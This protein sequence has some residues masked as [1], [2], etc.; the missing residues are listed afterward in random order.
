[1][2]FHSAAALAL[3]NSFSFLIPSYAGGNSNNQKAKST[4]KSSKKKKKRKTPETTTPADETRADPRR[5][6][7]IKRPDVNYNDSRRSHLPLPLQLNS[8][9]GNVVGGVV[10]GAVS[11]TQM[12]QLT[13]AGLSPDLL[14]ETQEVN[15]SQPHLMSQLRDASVPP[16]PPLD[17]EVIPEHND[18]VQDNEGN[19]IGDPESPAKTI[20]S[21]SSDNSSSSTDRSAGGSVGDD[22][23]EPSSAF[24]P[25]D[26]CFDEAARDFPLDQRLKHFM[27][28]RVITEQNRKP[29]ELVL[30][31]AAATFVIHEG[32]TDLEEQGTLLVNKYLEL[33]G[34][35]DD[36]MFVD[37][38]IQANMKLKMKG[39]Q[40]ELV[41]SS[42]VALFKSYKKKRAEIRKIFSRLPTDFST[43]KS[44]KQLYDIYEGFI[45]ACFI[46]RKVSLSHHK[47]NIQIT[48]MFSTSH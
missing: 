18:P 39:M 30:L 8:K 1:M 31:A 12:S 46:D 35:L 21:E 34:M 45:I 44:G 2:L 16:L 40:N 4:E 22:S 7:P 29:V 42:G 20:D 19:L 15:D 32:K 3:R 36:D 11:Q 17:D 14:A 5:K 6:S 25:Y 38:S 23:V 43:M 26:K 9:Y 33:L 10:G 37:E 41:A 24:D 27:K 48:H 47:T 28:G 13:T